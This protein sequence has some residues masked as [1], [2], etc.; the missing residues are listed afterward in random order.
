MTPNIGQTPEGG[1]ADYVPCLRN[2]SSIGSPLTAMIDA[3]AL[4]TLG[5]LAF[6]ADLS[7]GQPID[8]SPR[9]A[10]L[11]WRLAE[12]VAGDA[13]VSAC[14]SALGLIRWAGCT[15]NAQG[16]A[17]LF[18]DDIAGR[19]LLIEGQNPFHNRP[20]LSEPL[21]AYTRPLAQAHCEAT[22]EMVRQLGLSPA[23]GD[24]ALNLFEHWDGHGIPGGR[25]GE[26]I[27]LLAQVVALSG[28]IEIF[29]RVFGLS[30]GLHLIEMRAGRRYDPA[31]ARVALK[32]APAWLT[33]IAE[34]D[35]WPA[36]AAQ[37]GAAISAT[38]GDL[39]AFAELLADY[40][41]LKLPA[42]FMSSRRAAEIAAIT[43]SILGLDLQTQGRLV[44]AALLHGLGRVAVPN[45]TLERR[46]PLSEADEEHVRLIPHWT[47]RILKRAPVLLDEA[48]LACRAFE[49]LDGSGYPRGLGAPHLDPAARALQACVFVMTSSRRRSAGNDAPSLS[50][51]IARE[52]AAG[53]LD[54][55]AVAAVMT[56][57]GMPRRS[58]PS[59]TATST[60]QITQRER[61]VLEHLA[62]GS[63][64]KEIARKL[65]ISP[66]TAGTHI[67][68]LYR[69]LGVGTRAAAALIAAKQGLVN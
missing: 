12:V 40:G 2:V 47:E 15:A 67:E 1:R 44:R 16:F 24:G 62:T 63:S 59:R 13:A 46:T 21:E 23:V 45:A 7:M 55:G 39:N 11:A 60:A 52:V 28:D 58:M 42:D 43:G 30:K 32:H 56:A 41:D 25:R 53:T 8:H 6:A 27:H 69:K 31:L 22:V 14:A 64:N 26:E 36:A 3:P 33:E 17:D 65:G 54:P 9:T 10:L 48:T 20:A 37:A 38:E 18:G 61:E 34:Q 49:R 51:Q 35:A 19:A 5:C 68:S 57:C 29:S 66:S 4:Q 50:D